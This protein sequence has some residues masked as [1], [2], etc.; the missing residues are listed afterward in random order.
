VN[1][2]Q[3]LKLYLDL[4]SQI[5]EAENAKVPDREAQLHERQKLL[6]QLFFILQST[7][8]TLLDHRQR[9]A[10]IAA[11]AE[12]SLDET[13]EPNPAHERLQRLADIAHRRI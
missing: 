1:P 3:I 12:Q 5:L 13:P 9:L 8:R 4:N 7:E 6:D 2:S 10:E 11:Y